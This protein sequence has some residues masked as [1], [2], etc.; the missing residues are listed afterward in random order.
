[1]TD[2]TNVF[3]ALEFSIQRRFRLGFILFFRHEK[4][5]LEQSFALLAKQS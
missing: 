1:M 5:L 2:E 4:T 3:E